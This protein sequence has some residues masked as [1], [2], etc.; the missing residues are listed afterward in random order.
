MKTNHNCDTC[1]VSRICG[2]HERGDCTAC[3][4]YVEVIHNNI[5]F[6]KSCLCTFC[7]SRKGKPEWRQ[8]KTL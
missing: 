3:S 4:Y 2:K 8:D 7:R 1:E 5:K 6:G